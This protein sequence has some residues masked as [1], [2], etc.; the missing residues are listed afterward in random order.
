MNPISVRSIELT[1]A[2]RR[3]PRNNS[4]GLPG[5][6][7]AI[8]TPSASGT[9]DTIS[10]GEISELLLQHAQQFA[11]NLC[12]TA[13]GDIV[14]ISC[15]VCGA[16]S[17]GRDVSNPFDPFFNHL[18]GF[19][20]HYVAKQKHE[21]DL[22]GPLTRT[23]LP[24]ARKSKSPL[25]ISTSSPKASDRLPR[26]WRPTLGT[27]V[28]ARPSARLLDDADRTQVKRSRCVHGPASSH[29]GVDRSETNTTTASASSN[30]PSSMAVQLVVPPLV[31]PV[32]L[33]VVSSTLRTRS[34][35]SRANQWIS[36]L[37]VV[38]VSLRPRCSVQMGCFRCETTSATD[39]TQMVRS[40]CD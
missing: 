15:H 11:S 38:V 18:G 7:A 31:T 12:R 1:S 28:S 14:A 13:N 29:C 37:M 39:V 36:A 32:E 24:F 10:G 40:G 34:C 20:M 4:G 6:N 30:R 35:A 19:Q 25:P 21:L 16:N 27:V 9:T 17:S 2:V 8:D 26:D 23:S 3:K 5:S 22:A 33:V